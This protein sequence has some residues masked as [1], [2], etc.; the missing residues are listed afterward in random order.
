MK[1]SENAG[2]LFSSYL[3]AQFSSS[4]SVPLRAVHFQLDFQY[5]QLLYSCIKLPFNLNLGETQKAEVTISELSYA[6]LSVMGW[7]NHGK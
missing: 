5:H 6:M 3:F 4:C 1:L 7:G 2:G